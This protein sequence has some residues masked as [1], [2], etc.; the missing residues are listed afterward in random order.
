MTFIEVKRISPSCKPRMCVTV[1]VSE[2]AC[3]RVWRTCIRWSQPWKRDRSATHSAQ[4]QDLEL[5]FRRLL[6][7]GNMRKRREGVEHASL[8]PAETFMRACLRPM[9]AACFHVQE[10]A[11]NHQLIDAGIQRFLRH[12]YA[13]RFRMQNALCALRIYTQTLIGVFFVHGNGNTNACLPRGWN[14][15]YFDGRH[16]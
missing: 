7:H 4:W 8:R 14:L 11:S 1:S 5:I 13:A 16:L 2:L 9:E 3:M 10:C 6:Q 12:A 15:F